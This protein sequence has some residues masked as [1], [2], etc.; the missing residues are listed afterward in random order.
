MHNFG[1]RE[2]QKKLF[3]KLHQIAVG[4]LVLV[5]WQ[6]EHTEFHHSGEQ[7][8]TAHTRTHSYDAGKYSN[9][10]QCVDD[11]IGIEINSFCHM[12]KIA[13]SR[14]NFVRQMPKIEL[15]TLCVCVYYGYV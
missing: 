6:L 7:Q 11:M 8:I 1:Q 2:R 13:S 15:F 14:T 4:S 5:E 3:R 10:L 12:Y 9:M